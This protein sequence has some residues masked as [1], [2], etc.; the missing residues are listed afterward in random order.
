MTDQRYLVLEEDVRACGVSARATSE[1]D[2][3]QLSEELSR[4]HI[5]S[6]S[7]INEISKLARQALK[8]GTPMAYIGGSA[9]FAFMAQIFTAYQVFLGSSP[10][11][12]SSPG[13]SIIRNAKHEDAYEN[14]YK[15]MQEN[16]S[17][18]DAFF[19][20]D[21]NLAWAERCTGML[22]VYATIKRQRGE[23]AVC[24]EIV[25]TWYQ[26]VLEF[27]REAV[28]RQV[29][30]YGRNV[31]TVGNLN[32]FRGLEYKFLTIKYNLKMNLNRYEFPGPSE[33]RKLMEH[34]FLSGMVDRDEDNWAFM[35]D[36]LKVPVT[37]K[38]LDKVTDSQFK[39]IWDKLL[40]LR[41][42]SRMTEMYEE[43]AKPVQKLLLHKCSN[44]LSTEGVLG[45]YKKCSRC[46]EV[47]Y[48]SPECQKA[49]WKAG[50]KKS[51][52]AKVS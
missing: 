35:L 21:A 32:C 17:E 29:K 11:L 45:H 50:H 14:L 1:T 4:T 38:S 46:S 51:C 16:E 23:Y 48:C 15:C 40:K 37:K 42:D 43:A 25:T 30:K 18:F 41:M 34:E 7:T 12:S 6:A 24:D 26:K 39:V 47:F 9:D 8:S 3:D 2:P 28:N 13:A 20:D 33:L 19:A 52:N 44:C 49:D 36:F 27:Y 22:G 10:S 5:E 31:D